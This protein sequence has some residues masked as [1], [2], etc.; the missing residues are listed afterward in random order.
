MNRRRV[1][2]MAASSAAAVVPQT[3][4]AQGSLDK[5]RIASPPLNEQDT[6]LMYA[7]RN[8]LFRR[9]GLDVEVG[10]AGSGSAAVAAVVGGAYETGITSAPAV[11]YAHERGVP[12]EVVAPIALYT[13][14]GPLALLQMAADSTYKT[15]ADLN[16]KTIGAFAL[17]DIG[18]LSINVWTDQNGGD[19]SSLKFVEVSAAAIVQAIQSHR[20]EAA[21]VPSP[22]LEASLAAG[23]TKT[24]GD[25]LG[26]IAPRYLAS[27]M[28]AMKPWTDSHSDVLRR[29]NRALGEAA[30][31]V[32]THLRDTEALVADITK[33]E[34]AAVR[35]MHRSVSSSTLDAGLLQPVIDASAKYKFISRAFP[36]RE[37]VWGG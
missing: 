12:I 19:S 26:A 34:P 30:T 24:L 18:T 3:I 10:P 25:S 32:S 27:V 13:R 31:Y 29:F 1:L 17:N 37:V 16:G 21:I 36:A 9:V 6:S 23:T 4:R 20:V 2:T 5:V 8:G 33:L 14:A 15:G 22:L 28:V 35:G 7:V 11:L